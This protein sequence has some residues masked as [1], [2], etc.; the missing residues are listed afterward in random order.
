MLTLRGSFLG[1]TSFMLFKYC[2]ICKSKFFKPIVESRKNWEFR[3]KYCSRKCQF[4]GHKLLP[5]WSKGLKATDDSRVARFVEAG[6][7]ALKGKPIWN[8]GL[9]GVQVAWN[10]GLKNPDWLKEKNPNWRGGVTP[11]HHKVR[12]SSKYKDWRVSVFVRDNYTCQ[13]CGAR[14]GNGKRIILH[15]DHIKPFAL[16]PELRFEL[17]NG[18]TLC[19]EC[20][21]I[22]TALDGKQHWKN[23]YSWS[24][25]RSPI[26]LS[27]VKVRL[28]KK[29]KKQPIFKICPVCQKEFR[30]P[31]SLMRLVCCSKKCGTINRKGKPPQIDNRGKKPWN[32]GKTNVYSEE[33]KKAM[34]AKNAGISR[35]F[36][37]QFGQPKGWKRLT[38]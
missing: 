31:K 18:M 15:A 9:K 8:K 12:K 25:K 22:K 19:I 35:S 29:P 36:E 33:T 17:S 27:K 7:K 24:S 21:E 14:N 4:E 34:G 23:Q 10:K 11:E 28:P 1:A 32:A 16:Y 37:T 2:L 3:H 5:G 38:Q 26:K 6:H 13:K 20:H 30:V